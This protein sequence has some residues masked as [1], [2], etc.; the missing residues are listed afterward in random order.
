[1]TE[2]NNFEEPFKNNI[3]EPYTN[4][5]Q[6]PFTNNIQ[7][8][9]TNNIQEPFTNN[10]QEPFTNNIQEPFTNNMQEPFTNNMQEPYTNNIPEFYQNNC[11]N[12]ANIPTPYQNDT[13]RPNNF[14]EP[15][16]NNYPEPYQ[17]NNQGL[18]QNNN[19]GPIQNNTYQ[20][21][22]NQ[23]NQ[24]IGNEKLNTKMKPIKAIFIIILMIIF[25]S[26]IVVDFVGLSTFC[27]PKTHHD[28][29]ASYFGEG[30][31]ILAFIFLYYPI[32]IILS[33]MVICLSSF[34]KLPVVKIFVSVIIC[35]IR[36]FII[37]RF[38]NDYNKKT[39]TFA[40]VLII[41]DCLLM[42]AS[43]SYQIIIKIN[44]NLPY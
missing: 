25:I 12:Q 16:Q 20:N 29:E 7:E 19:P 38:I 41:L 2:V 18:S 23:V 22:L 6:E 8:P 32:L 39:E 1:M 4:N 15:Y 33:S 44:L 36:G 17:N 43:I 27:E 37:S 5:N 24:E 21:N 35:S 9:F 14:P 26:E 40:I 11:Q 3:Q 42:I 13:L 28:P 34:D 31:I 30:L 10:I